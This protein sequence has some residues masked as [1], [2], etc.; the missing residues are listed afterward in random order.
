M[1][2]SLS[3]EAPQPLRMERLAIQRP[4]VIELEDESSAVCRPA[5]SLDVGGSFEIHRRLLYSAEA[6][7]LGS[8]WN[9]SVN[10]GKRSQSMVMTG[11]QSENVTITSH[12]DVRAKSGAK[13]SKKME[14]VTDKT[15]A[16][17]GKLQP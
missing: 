1:S 8:V 6:S 16:S 13:S 11:R 4:G 9:S 12:D 10:E 5:L 3:T 2:V 17:F 7:W 14:D 15:L